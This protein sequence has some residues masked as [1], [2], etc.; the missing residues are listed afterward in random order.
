[1]Y[2][3]QHV[4]KKYKFQE[5]TVGTLEIISSHRME[6]ILKNGHFNIISQLHSIQAIVRLVVPHADVLSTLVP[7]PI[8]PL[9]SWY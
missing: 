5:I 6:K 2:D 9:W 7:T 3:V 4:G 8:I 1:M